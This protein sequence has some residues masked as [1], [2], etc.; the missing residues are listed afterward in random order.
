MKKVFIAIFLFTG[1]AFQSSAQDHVVAAKEY[2]GCFS[3]LKD[4]LDPEFRTMLIRVAKE[5]DVKS[6]FIKEM[7]SLDAVKQQKLGAQ[8]EM[9]GTSIDSEKTEAGRC[10]IALD[11]KYEKYNDT[12]EKEKDFNSKMAAELKKN[13]DC[14]FVWAITVFALAFGDEED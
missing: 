5:T 14:E 11:K 10:G 6:A 3:M 7:T 12:P 4:T 2:C 9:M 8:L 13:K 1:I